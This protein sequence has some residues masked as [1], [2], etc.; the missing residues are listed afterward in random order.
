MT[1]ALLAVG[2][3]SFGHGK[4]NTIFTWSHDSHD[5]DWVAKLAHMDRVGPSLPWRQ[6]L[7]SRAPEDTGSNLKRVP[8]GSSS[9]LP[10]Q[11]KRLGTADT[12]RNSTKEPG[13]QTESVPG[14]EWW[15][16]TTT[17]DAGCE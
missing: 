13:R 12:R 9:G 4:G 17:S 7:C 3:R 15:H 14:N 2:M 8:S 16:K 6:V 1:K 10:E 5:L 11:R